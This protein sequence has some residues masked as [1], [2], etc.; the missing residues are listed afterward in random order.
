MKKLLSVLLAVALVLSMSVTVFAADEVEIALTTDNYGT[1]TGTA[2][3]ALTWGDNSVLAPDTAIFSLKLPQ[4]VNDGDTVVVHIKGNSEGDF[5]VWLLG[6]DEAAGAMEKTCSNQFKASNVG[7]TTGDFEYYIELVFQDYDGAG[8][9]SAEE[10][11]IKGPSYGTNLTNTRLDY[12]G[13]YYGSLA[14][15]DVVALAEAQPDIDAAQAAID[16]A[17]AAVGG[18]VAALQA[19]IDAAQAAVDVVAAKA[20]LGFTSVMSA[21]DDLQAQIDAMQ[22][23]IVMAGFQVHIDTVN[24][25]L[26]DA[27]AAGNDITKIKAA[28]DAAVAAV[29]TMEAE[30]NGLPAVTEKVKELKTIINEIKDLHKAATAANAAAKEA[31]EAAAKEAEEKAAAEAAAKEASTKTTITV[32]VIVAVVVVI[33]AV[34]LVVLKKKKK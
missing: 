25:A 16:A 17:K 22:G 21:N 20:A 11:A 24:T 9:T 7:F 14:D 26:E 1:Y 30:G 6:A 31:E 27:K 15:L 34:V 33:L 8:L 3:D 10:L 28:Y 23:D 18:D 19:A 12:V 29:D 4:A 32:V 5:R 2:A 13:V